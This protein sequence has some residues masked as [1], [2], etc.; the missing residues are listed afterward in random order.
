MQPEEFVQRIQEAGQLGAVYSDV[1]RSKALIA[2]V[3]AATVTDPSGSEV[4]MSDLL[5]EDEPETSE[6]PED[7][8]EAT[9]EV[10]AAE[11]TEASEDTP[12][13]E[14]EEKAPASS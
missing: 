9:P 8:R 6:A 10:A 7:A 14:V 1:R 11:A 4:D 3:R 13:A 5:G 12:A 2:A